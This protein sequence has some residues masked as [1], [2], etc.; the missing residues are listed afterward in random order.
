MNSIIL[1]SFR[2]LLEELLL[3]G[4]S[5]DLRHLSKFTKHLKQVLLRHAVLFY[6]DS[7]VRESFILKL[8]QN[9]GKIFSLLYLHLLL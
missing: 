3:Y 4:Y 5:A 9:C 6:A 8:L 7:K 2:I 1:L